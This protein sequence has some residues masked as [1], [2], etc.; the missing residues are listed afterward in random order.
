MSAAAG[1]ERAEGLV[2]GRSVARRGR[3][4]SEEVR[5]RIFQATIELLEERGFKELT[6]EAI[7]ERAG[8]SKVTLYRWWPGKA[9]L[10]TDAFLGVAGPLAP[11]GH[12]DSALVDLREQMV[13]Q[14]RVLAGRWGKI[15]AGLIAE[16]VFDPEVREAMR[17]RW[18]EPR[19]A[20]GRK[21][22][23]R[24]LVD[25]E[26]RAGTDPEVVLDALYA[27]L[28]WRLLLGHAPLHAAFARQV[29]SAAL[30]GIA[31]DAARARLERPAKAKR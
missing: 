26:L 20:E 24:A 8:A 6:I 2:E 23:E 19:R 13:S 9:A 16:S 4:R 10:A 11:F 3:P 14:M 28:Y 12:T 5:A 30:L 22:V 27:P 21:V 25:G 31:T 15:I 29:W 17:T 18:L 7:A 1:A